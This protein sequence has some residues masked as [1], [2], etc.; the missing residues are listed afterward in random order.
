[1]RRPHPFGPLL[2]LPLL[3]SLILSAA[4]STPSTS[5]PADGGNGAAG[6]GAPKVQRVVFAIVPIETE[7][8]EVR[9][10]A[11]QTFL[12]I[13]PVYEY[14][15]GSNADTG[16][17]EPQL[18]TEW[19][20]EPDGKAF[21]FKLRK[22]V[23]FHNDYGEFTAKDLEEPLR[24]RMRTDFVTTLAGYWRDTLDRIEVMNDYEAVY[25]LKRPDGNYLLTMSEQRGSNEIFSKKNFD[26]KGQPTLEQPMLAGTAPYQF[27]ERQQSQFIRYKAVPFKHWRAN[28]DF[29]E[30]E[31]RFMKEPSTRLASLLTGEAQMATLPEDLLA[32]AE[33]QG[34]KIVAGR[35]AGLRTFVPMYCCYMKDPKDPSKGVMNPDSPLQNVTVRKALAKAINVDE[36]NKAIF[37][38]KGTRMVLPHH[39]PTRPGW[40]PDWERRYQEAYGYDPEAAK[41]LLAEAGYGPN[42]PVVTNML[43]APAAGYSGGEEVEEAIATQWRAIGVQ[44]N[45]VNMESTDRDRTLRALKFDNHAIVD[46]TGSDMWTGTT[47]GGS[48]LGVRGRGVELPDL[49]RILAEMGN[50]LDEKK[51]DDLWRQAGEVMFTQ[52]QSLPLL[53]LPTQVAVRKDVVADYAFPGTITG[54]WTHLYNIKA[55]K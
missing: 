48:T 35:A 1:M 41:R 28:P 52:Y 45:L 23:Q 33:K 43:L 40:N 7:S 32:N 5:Q 15:I 13:R 20:L 44:T 34:A 49:D 50:T 11:G 16:K 27:A 54:S 21:R 42:K 18:A 55:A 2:A 36:I 53:W 39:H 12:Q 6:G 31:F 17:Y 4:C 26:E 29:P 38:G 46:A 10:L 22:G 9:V 25:H 24:Q 3:V 8:N 14:L 47:N 19:N 37:G 51:Q 30:V